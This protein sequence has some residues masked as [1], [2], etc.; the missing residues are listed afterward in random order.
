M[1]I[2]ALL[3][4]E[5]SIRLPPVRRSAGLDTVCP[6]AVSKSS[7]LALKGK[8]LLRKQTLGFKLLHIVV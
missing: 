3:R 2:Y 5:I 1:R 7:K 6:L 4:S 8:A